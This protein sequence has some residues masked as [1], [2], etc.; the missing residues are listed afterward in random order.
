MLSCWDRV[1]G[2][3]IS[4]FPVN[5]GLVGSCPFS[6]AGYLDGVWG[7]KVRQVVCSCT[8]PPK[9]CWSPPLPASPSCRG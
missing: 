1:P 9:A 5:N 3:P 7:R 8:P 4:P 2:P 6:P